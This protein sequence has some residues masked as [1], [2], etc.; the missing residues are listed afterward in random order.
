[1]PPFRRAALQTGIGAP[2]LEARGANVLRS[3]L[4]VAQRAQKAA[5]PLAARLECL[6]RMKEACSLLRHRGRCIRFLLRNRPV[7][8]SQP[9]LA[10]GTA[11]PSARRLCRGHSATA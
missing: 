6:L 8:N 11:L 3:E 9:L 2:T 10:V 1:M 7:S 5:A 4:Q